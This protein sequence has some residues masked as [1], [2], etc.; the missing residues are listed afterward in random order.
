MTP[1]EMLTA[2]GWPIVED[3][4]RAACDAVT[5][6]ASDR[7]APP[8]R[9]H[10]SMVSQAG[11]AIHVCVLGVVQLALLIKLPCLADNKRAIEDTESAFNI[12]FERMLRQ[13][14]SM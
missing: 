11:N 13:K 5:I 14:K 8:S 7:P 1:T 4:R 6:F 10:S 12:G 3:S 2:M 9:S